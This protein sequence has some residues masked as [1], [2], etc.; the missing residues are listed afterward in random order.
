MASTQQTTQK[1]TYNIF[2]KILMASTQQ[3]TQK[4]TYNI[5]CKISQKISCKTFCLIG[6]KKNRWKVAKFCAY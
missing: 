2:C 5:F 1:P 3:T 4:P 6:E